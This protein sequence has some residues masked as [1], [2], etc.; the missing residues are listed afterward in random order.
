MNSDD[1][2][3]APER[4]HRTDARRRD[5]DMHSG[6]NGLHVS[7]DIDARHIPGLDVRSDN[8]THDHLRTGPMEKPLCCHDARS[9][10]STRN[11][12]SLVSLGSGGLNE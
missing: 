9:R 5:P 2:S 3:R 4:L 7:G 1:S 12:C 11:A 6:K 8:G 10:R